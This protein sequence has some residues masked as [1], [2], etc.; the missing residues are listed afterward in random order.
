MN[1]GQ[2]RRRHHQYIKALLIAHKINQAIFVVEDHVNK[3]G[4]E[5]IIGKYM[6]NIRD[7]LPLYSYVS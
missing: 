1:D 3:T 4:E 7:I 2:Q 6:P 5:G